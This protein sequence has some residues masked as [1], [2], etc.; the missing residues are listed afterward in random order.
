MDMVTEQTPISNELRARQRSG[1]S[2]TQKPAQVVARLTMI[3][4][5]AG[6]GCP[7]IKRAAATLI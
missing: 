1:E 2:W 4:G 6:H 7:Q 3:L 5:A